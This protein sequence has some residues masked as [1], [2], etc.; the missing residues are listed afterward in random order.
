MVRPATLRSEYAKVAYVSPWPKGKAGF[1]LFLSYL[2]RVIGNGERRNKKATKKGAR[3]CDVKA[4]ARS[5]IRI[6]SELE[7]WQ[8]KRRLTSGKPQFVLQNSW[9]GTSIPCC[10]DIQGQ[11]MSFCRRH[12]DPEHSRRNNSRTT[13][14]HSPRYTPR[15]S[16]V[17]RGHESGPAGGISS[18]KPMT[19]SEQLT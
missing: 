17:G 12:R 16:N 6:S 11:G 2:C 8:D 5:T 19:E 15:S 4:N 13:G 14:S 7:S 18:S 3:D 1:L 10:D 9:P